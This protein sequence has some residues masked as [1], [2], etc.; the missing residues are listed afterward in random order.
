MTIVVISV[1]RTGRVV[2]IVGHRFC[3]V[4]SRISREAW[5]SDSACRRTGK[6]GRDRMMSTKR[7]AG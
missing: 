7:L 6:A 5:V 4:R 2:S 1:N 3:V